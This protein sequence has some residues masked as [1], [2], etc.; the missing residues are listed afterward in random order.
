MAFETTEAGSAAKP[1]GKATRDSHASSHGP[2]GPAVGLKQRLE[3]VR[4]GLRSLLRL[5]R[6]DEHARDP[7]LK[8]SV[9]ALFLMPG[10]LV[11]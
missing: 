11:G 7:L 1:K 4:R 2:L 10:Y 6:C 9:A 5:Q 8:G 3:T